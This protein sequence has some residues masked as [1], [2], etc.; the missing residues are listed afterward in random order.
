MKCYGFLTEYLWRIASSSPPPQRWS[1]MGSVPQLLLMETRGVGDGLPYRVFHSDLYR[2]NQFYVVKL[3]C[4]WVFCMMFH[5]Y[6]IEHLIFLAFNSRTFSPRGPVQFFFLVCTQ[7]RQAEELQIP[8]MVESPQ[9][10]S[11]DNYTSVHWSTKKLCREVFNTGTISQ[12]NM[13]LLCKNY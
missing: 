7:E 1:R 2:E 8:S 5:G 12:R 10:K 6:I 11:S 4:I 13:T 9:V 3:W